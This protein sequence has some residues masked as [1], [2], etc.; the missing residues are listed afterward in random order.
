MDVS[1]VIV[2]RDT[3]SFTCA[4]IRSVLESED[5]L[6]KEVIVVDNGSADATQLTIAKEFPSVQYVRSETNLGFGRAN[7]LGAKQARGELILLLNSDARLKRDSLAQAVPWMRAHPECG[8]CGVQLL[9]PDGSKQNSI[10]NFPSLAT[11]LLNKSLLR[12]LFP[13][14]F[15]GKE[16]QL[17]EP[18]EV[19]SIVGAFF[20]MPRN[21]WQTL[22]GFDE[23]YF[24]FF[25]ETDL[26]LQVRR[27]GLKIF[28]LP[29]VEVWHEQGKS[30]RQWS[31]A[32]RIEYWRS[33]YGYF[34]KNHSSF[35]T[36]FLRIGLQLRLLVEL[37]ASC[38]VNALTLGRSAR[39]KQ[40]LSTY[41]KLSHWH[42]RGCPAEWGLPR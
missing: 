1:V 8:I 27:K 37:L 4:A 35:T 36:A 16:R 15:P 38:V 41:W 28:H 22:G 26:C 25:E 32:A 21:L 12:R 19:N 3:C 23:R 20:L 29:Q 30:A 10:A 24:F 40:K 13:K 11:E 31:A 5:D 14:R 18:T 34:R 7:N 39:W 9:N 17:S 42:W 6:R 33:R 2:T